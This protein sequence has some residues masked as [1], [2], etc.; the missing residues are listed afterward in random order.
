MKG[1]SRCILFLFL[2]LLPSFAQQASFN[3]VDI[4]S[5]YSLLRTPSLSMNQHGFNGSMG[6]NVNRW[7]GLSTDFSIYGGSGNPTLADTKLTPLF[8]GVS[9]NIPMSR[10]TSI[11]TFGPQ[12]NIRQHKIIM[13]W[14]RTG[15]GFFHASTTYNF[16][17][18][19]AA[20]VLLPSGV[21]QNM[22]DTGV[23]VR[24]GGGVD[25]KVTNDFSVRTA[26]D[27]VYA[28]PDQAVFKTMGAF[29]ISIGTKWSLSPRQP[30]K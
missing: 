8:P 15:L 1:V 24:V 7:L 23:A 4:S 10:T 2:A 30:R 3:R 17:G 12:I 21:S 13:P 9:T 14:I 19:G 28:N 5:G 11:L 16:G 18:L 27:Y 20:V 25:F 26:A 29:T 22:T 6:F